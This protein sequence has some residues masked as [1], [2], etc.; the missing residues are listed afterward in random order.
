[1]NASVLKTD[2]VARLPGVRI[3]PFPKTLTL[4]IIMLNFL[5]RLLVKKVFGIRKEKNKEKLI[6]IFFKEDESLMEIFSLNID[7]NFFFFF[8]CYT[9]VLELRIQ[10]SL[11]R[12]F[13][14]C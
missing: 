6:K 3:P 10:F 8:F 5:N 11:I 9:I 2:V 7:K 13:I 4:R 14:A 1:M 12:F